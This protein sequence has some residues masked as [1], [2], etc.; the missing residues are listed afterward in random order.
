MNIQE[1]KNQIKELKAKKEGY[2]NKKVRLEEN[3]KY[4]NNSLNEIVSEMEALGVTPDNI[5]DKINELTTT[6][7]TTIEKVNSI[8]QSNKEKEEK[9]DNELPI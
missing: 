3:L 7:E 2:D 9:I 8:L 1:M 5:E 6:I 4:N